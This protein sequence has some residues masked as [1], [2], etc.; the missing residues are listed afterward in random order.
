MGWPLL[1]HGWIVGSEELWGQS[2]NPGVWG[3]SKIKNRVGVKL[4]VQWVQQSLL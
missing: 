1:M 3:Q 4:A 2:K